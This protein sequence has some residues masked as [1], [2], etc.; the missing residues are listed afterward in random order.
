ML[1]SGASQNLYLEENRARQNYL[2]QL[3]KYNIGGLT[4]M[5]MP[6][7]A[8]L[9]GPSNQ[10]QYSMQSRSTGRPPKSRAKS[11]RGNNKRI[12]S[13]MYRQRNTGGQHPYSVYTNPNYDYSKDP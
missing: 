7:T 3:Q 4:T 10:S 11:P 13:N 6:G 2:E 9:L 8:N 12:R 5:A 1:M